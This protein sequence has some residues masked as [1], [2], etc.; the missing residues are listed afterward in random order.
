MADAGIAQ[1]LPTW[2]V[3]LIDL[4]EVATALE[5]ILGWLNWPFVCA[6]GSFLVDILIDC[7]IL[8]EIL[9]YI[10]GVIQIV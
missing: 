2:I 10:A 4:K 6:M 1:V 3:L 5:D 7:T 8:L 9:I